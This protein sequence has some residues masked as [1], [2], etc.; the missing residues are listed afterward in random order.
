MANLNNA[1]QRFRTLIQPS[2]TFTSELALKTNPIP[3]LSPL[4]FSDIKSTSVRVNWERNADWDRIASEKIIIPES[5]H[6]VYYK[7]ETQKYEL[8]VDITEDGVE[9]KDLAPD[10]NYTFEL[11]A[12]YSFG[13]SAPA[14]SAVSTSPTLQNVQIRDIATTAARVE[15]NHLPNAHAYYITVEP[16]LIGHQNPIEVFSN[17]FELTNLARESEFSISIHAELG[18]STTDTVR[19]LTF[20]TSPE[21]PLL[22]I[23]DITST[24]MK[25]TS[26]HVPNAL[27]YQISYFATHEP[28]FDAEIILHGHDVLKTLNDLEP[29]TDYTFKLRAVF[30]KS[31]TD[32]AAATYKTGT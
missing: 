25:L 5:L 16:E 20:V 21:P 17:M 28:E 2:K 11:R 22:L 29:E 30:E 24:S 1:N 15:W 32:W 31:V 19:G 9:V 4:Q 26:S 14:I 23:D 3:Q 13:I 8:E 12:V 7:E 10:W 27:K 6:L 18:D